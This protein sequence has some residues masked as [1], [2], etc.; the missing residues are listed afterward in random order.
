MSICIICI[1]TKEPCGFSK[2]KSFSWNLLRCPKNE[3]GKNG[4][5][6]IHEIQVLLNIKKQ[7]KDMQNDNR[8]HYPMQIQF[9]Y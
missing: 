6:L 8:I 4:D 3:E 2:A 1:S 9:P 5:S 7:L